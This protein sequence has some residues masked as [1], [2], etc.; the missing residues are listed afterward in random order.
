MQKCHQL[1]DERY[2][3]PIQGCTAELQGHKFLAMHLVVL[4]A[5]VAE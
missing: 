5:P 3:C 1:A 2:N 4:H